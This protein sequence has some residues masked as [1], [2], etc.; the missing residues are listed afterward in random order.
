MTFHAKKNA[1]TIRNGKIA[2][3]V[4]HVT[5]NFTT[6]KEGH[7]GSFHWQRGR[8]IGKSLAEECSV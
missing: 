6:I 4:E 3:F 5:V 8:N 7:H 1:N 2:S